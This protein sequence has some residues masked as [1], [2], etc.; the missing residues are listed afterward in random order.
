[1]MSKKKNI[2]LLILTI[3]GF[4]A[5]LLLF[6]KTLKIDL[7]FIDNICVIGNGE[8][9]NCEKIIQ[10]N[11]SKMF[12]IQQSILLLPIFSGL[13]I[14]F[15][16][17]V[18]LSEEKL[19]SF[20]IIPFMVSIF[21]LVYSLFMAFYMFIV[22][23]GPYDILSLIIY[24]VSIA[25]LI[26]MIVP[27]LKTLTESIKK[28][29]ITPIKNN[30]YIFVPIPILILC[31]VGGIL[32]NYYYT[33]V[34]NPLFDQ[35]KN[36][37]TEEL[38]A[39]TI[40]EIS[41]ENSPTLGKN[42]LGVEIVVFEDFQCP[43]CRKTSKELEKLLEHYDYKITLTYKHYPLESECFPQ[44]INDLHEFACEASWASVAALKQNKFW[45]YYDLLFS[46][47]L[48]SLDKLE[49]YAKKIDLNME[50]YKNDYESSEV[51]NVVRNDTEEGFRLGIMSTPTLFFN[52]RLYVGRKRFKELKDIV[53]YII[54]GEA[55][56]DL[57]EIQQERE[58]TE[59]D[60][61]EEDSSVVGEYFSEEVFEFDLSESPTRGENEY[62]VNIIVFEDFQC[63]AC[64]RTSDEIKKLLEHYDYNISLTF[65]HYPLESECFPVEIRDL[66]EF[67]CEASW[68]S[69]AAM[70]QDKFWE[71]YDILFS[72]KIENTDILEE[73]ANQIELDIDKFNQDY[74]SE[75][76]K[77]IVRK[78]TT[79]GLELNIM[80]TPTLFFN[81]RLYSG[82]KHFEDLVK[83]VEYIMS[84]ENN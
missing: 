3:I 59:N 31:V 84:E 41:T 67:G 68:A 65:K 60:Y 77:D 49:K 51:R 12:G 22:T 24:A 70:K 72:D 39:P 33:N 43:A 53:E 6:F 83:A 73:Y 47:R 14:F 80:S 8:L 35:I 18:F 23:K 55:D 17:G 19:N 57:E 69:I 25:I 1:M 78:D 11:W 28:I 20:L 64:R 36:I 75:T 29:F 30:I 40:T 58:N 10:A 5:V 54:S 74:S 32:L 34:W 50:K 82:E 63:P 46:S 27:Y 16:I 4:I 42:E 15:A 76:T 9:F 81:G 45:E 2:I 26:I 37:P 48:D 44:P 13:L 38:L 62:G 52:G 71:Y 61:E 21:N 7:A 66:H 56:K 79:E